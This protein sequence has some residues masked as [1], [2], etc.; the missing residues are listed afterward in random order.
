[1]TPKSV[2]IDW[3]SLELA[4]ESNMEEISQYLD[5]E[6]GKVLWYDPDGHFLGQ[7][8]SDLTEEELEGNPDR[9][10]YIDGQDSHEG[11]RWME[12]FAQ[13]QEDERA[14]EF[15][16]FALDGP[17]P[18]RRFKDALYKFPEIQKEWFEYQRECQ[19]IDLADWLITL[20]IEIANPPDWFLKRKKEWE[21][22]EEDLYNQ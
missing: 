4:F 11:Y 5:L 14:R 15:L 3:D 18:F 17:K 19:L 22:E 13:S 9:Y 1:M 20:P 6:T 10:K 12:R 2:N 21:N 16:F 8:E 7:G